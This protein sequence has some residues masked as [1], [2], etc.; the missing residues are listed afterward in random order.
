MDAIIQRGI[1]KLDK[2]GQLAAPI[3]HWVYTRL[4]ESK[5]KP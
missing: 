5:R 3:P 4:F 2:G 1:D